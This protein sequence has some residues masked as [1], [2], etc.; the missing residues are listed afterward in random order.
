MTGQVPEPDP[1]VETSYLREACTGPQVIP[2]EFL[3]YCPAAL[4]AAPETG[5]AVVRQRNCLK[6]WA[7]P[8]QAG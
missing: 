6:P 8:D 1:A 3:E 2:V 4:A 5:L 7:Q